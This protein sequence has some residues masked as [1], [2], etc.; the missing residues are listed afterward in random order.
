MSLQN[1]KKLRAERGFT[2]VE[3]L[4]VIVVIGI[5]AAIVVVAYNGIQNKAK[6]TQ[7]L[8]DAQTIAKKAEAYNAEISGG[9]YPLLA[10]DFGAAGAPSSSLPTGVTVGAVIASATAAPANAAALQTPRAYSVH[11]CTTGRGGIRVY[12][13]DP[14]TS[15]TAIKYVDAGT[16]AASC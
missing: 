6:T 12:Y 2:I 1:I 11:V 5:L 9:G 15:A 3:L 7:Y 10:S 14:G 8:T 16:W 13:P 4:I